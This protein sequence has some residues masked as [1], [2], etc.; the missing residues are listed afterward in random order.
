MWV[1]QYIYILSTYLYVY[2]FIVGNELVDTLFLRMGVLNDKII[3]SNK[4]KKYNFID[5]LWI[6]I[7]IFF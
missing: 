2:L 6:I 5:F 4:L 1:T 3:K 7:I